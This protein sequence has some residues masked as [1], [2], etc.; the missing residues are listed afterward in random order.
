MTDNTELENKLLREFNESGKQNLFRFLVDQIAIQL[1]EREIL[2]EAYNLQCESYHTK[3]KHGNELYTALRA[4]YEDQVD[5]LT[6]NNL[7]GIY[8]QVMKGARKALGLPEPV[9]GKS[10]G[11]TAEEVYRTITRWELDDTPLLCLCTVNKPCAY[12]AMFSKPVVGQLDVNIPHRYM[13]NNDLAPSV[14]RKAVWGDIYPYAP[15][16]PDTCNLWTTTPIEPQLRCSCSLCRD[17]RE[18]TAK[19]EAQTPMAKDIYAPKCNWWVGIRE[20][21]CLT[22]GSTESNRCELN[23]R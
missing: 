11:K 6:T 23:K 13:I 8:N 5:Y 15:W 22:C 14:P 7:E 20:M 12:H 3:V 1:R 17:L 16:K 9:A 2:A 18:R 21:W 4:L 10:G 19:K